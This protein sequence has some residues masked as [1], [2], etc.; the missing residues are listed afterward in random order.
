MKEEIENLKKQLDE[1]SQEPSGGEP[2]LHDRILS[3]EQEL[4]KLT[5]EL[6]EKMRFVPKVVDRPGSGA[7]RGGG[8]HDR[9]PSQSGSFEESRSVEFTE[10]PRSRGT[11]D[12]WARPTD[13]RRAFQGSRERGFLGSRD[14]DRLAYVLFFLHL[15]NFKK[16]K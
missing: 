13:D 14:L 7:G 9:T 2:G 8:Y 6:D 11:S 4:E 15:Y 16:C 5:R 3:L 12:M 1:P 10:R